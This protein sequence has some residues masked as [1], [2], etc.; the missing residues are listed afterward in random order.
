MPV[1][2]D[3][4]TRARQ[5]ILERR[6]RSV[7]RNGYWLGYVE[8]A[9]SRPGDLDRQRAGLGLIEAVTPEQLQALAQR[10]LTDD[11]AIP[12]RVSSTKK[13]DAAPSDEGADAA[14]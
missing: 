9:Q 3:L 8:E 12:V 13:A 10:F 7:K 2:E 5:P 1:S 11:Q 6:E 14:L 4:L